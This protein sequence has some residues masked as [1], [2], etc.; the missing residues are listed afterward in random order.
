M[1]SKQLKI[2]IITV[3]LN[4]KE[5][6]E[7]CI[8]SVL[9]QTYPHIE[10]I[11]VDGDSSDGTREVLYQY[12]VRLDRL[13]SEKDNGIAQAMNKGLR[14]ATGDYILFLNADDYLLENHTIEKA[15]GRMTGD[16]DIHGFSVLYGGDE[17][18][19]KMKSTPFSFMI[20]FKTSIMH[21]GAFCKRELFDRIGP[22]NE[23]FSIAMDYDFFLR[24]YHAKSSIQCHGYPTS[25]M[26]D[27]GVSSQTDFKSLQKRFAEERDAH[28]KN[29]IHPGMKM[30]Y[31][32]Y[33]VLYPIYR[34]IKW[35]K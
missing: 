12:E 33:W 27:T 5:H 31:H 25:F 6:I 34:R 35:I 1:N 15:V 18:T 22:F 14:L 20:N 24:A 4:A 11:I 21:Q 2:S 7:T 16:I 26:R 28:Y 9:S 19:V 17:K 23:T 10:Y 8:N 13:V 29:V 32:M 3:C 30:L